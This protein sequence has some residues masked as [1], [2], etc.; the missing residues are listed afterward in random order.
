MLDIARILAEHENQIEADYPPEGEFFNIDGWRLHAV[1][2]GKGPDVILMHGAGGS[3]R[4]MTYRLLPALSDRYR[5]TAVDRPGHGYTWSDKPMSVITP[6]QQARLIWR[7]LEHRGIE[8]PLILGQS[9]G[10]TVAIAMAGTCPGRARGYSLVSAASTDAI[11]MRSFWGR[12]S[13][14][15]AH[16]VLAAPYVSFLHDRVITYV[17]EKLFSPDPIPDGYIKHFGPRMSLRKK[18]YLHKTQ[19]VLCLKPC[20]TEMMSWYEGLPD[21]FDVVHGDHDGLLPLETHAMPFSKLAPGASLSVIKG[22]G[23]MPHQTHT[24]EVVESVHRLA[25]SR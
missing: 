17:L 23:H 15:K 25:I 24:H 6:M 3:T 11:E 2:R 14:I 9:Y 4:D 22:A 18:S 19:Q 13:I 5:V 20:L 8:R 7:F 12:E 16:E 1:T 21:R 10:G